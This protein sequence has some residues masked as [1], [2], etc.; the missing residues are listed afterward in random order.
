[1]MNE[2]L[3]AIF[4]RRSIRNFQP[5][6][7]TDDQM[8]TLIQVAL[9]SPTGMNRQSW[10][11]HFVVNTEKIAALSEASLET[12][13]RQGNQAVLDS[14]AARHTSLFYGAPL[15]IIISMPKDSISGVDAGIAVENLVIA[16]ESMGL[17]SC[18]IGLA[19]A[20]FSGEQADEMAR[21]IEMPPDNAFVIAIA[22]GSK[23]M[24]KEAHARNPEKI[25]IIR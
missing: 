3:Q 25:T 13:R 17:G 10:Q 22:I 4:D 16:A 6:P 8:E 9:A 7:L 14:M 15:V 11:F 23:A 12:F 19:G 18:I 2:T 5:E 24:T 21:L 1:M 20:A